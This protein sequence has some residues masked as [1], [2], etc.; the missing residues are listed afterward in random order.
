MLEEKRYGEH[1]VVCKHQAT[2]NTRDHR[3][4]APFADCSDF[5]FDVI[6]EFI[7]YMLLCIIFKCGYSLF[8]RLACRQYSGFRGLRAR[9]K[10]QTRLNDPDK[11]AGNV[12]VAR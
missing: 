4:L 1:P 10:R 6:M 5:S 3:G 9:E 8:Y 2:R 7:A 11:V 12:S